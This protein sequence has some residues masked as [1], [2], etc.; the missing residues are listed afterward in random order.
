MKVFS[1]KNI[2]GMAVFSAISFLVY[3]IE[4]PIFA[5]TPV[6]FL[7]LDLSNVFVLLAGFMY[8]PIPALI[9]SLVK[10]LLHILVGTTGGVGE[11]ANI[12]ITAFYILIPTIAYRKKKGL[13]IVI[14][15]LVLGCIVQSFISLLVNRFINFPFFLGGAPFIPTESSDA[16]Y[17][18]VWYFILIFNFIK[19]VVVSVITVLIY[20]KT[21]Y[22]FKKINLQN[23]AKDV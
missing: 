17:F 5:A 4:I 2:A 15:T 16:F 3:L 8:G 13:K 11:F 7:K 20:K 18:S 14:I 10:E 23:S 1:T 22:L 9:V 6:S 12:I 21:S 19:S